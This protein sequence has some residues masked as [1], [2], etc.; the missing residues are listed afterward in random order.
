MPDWWIN[1]INDINRCDLQ[2]NSRGWLLYIDSH[3]SLKNSSGLD[4]DCYHGALACICLAVT[5]V[6]Q[7]GSAALAVVWNSACV[8]NHRVSTLCNFILF[9]DKINDE[10]ADWP[11]LI[12][13]RSNYQEVGLWVARG[14]LAMQIL[15]NERSLI[16]FVFVCNWAFSTFLRTNRH[17]CAW[18]TG[19]SSESVPLT[20]LKVNCSKHWLFAGAVFF[21][22][23]A[24][25]GEQSGEE[26]PD[27]PE[28]GATLGACS[29]FGPF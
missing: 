24:Q 20:K 11:A 14:S 21:A 18:W 29:F 22:L 23:F 1:I 3:G 4:V 9:E 26:I 27:L 12:Q 13:R 2:L 28:P 7:D 16:F 25:S 10:L 15:E 8:S 17:A 5:T 19:E 6:N